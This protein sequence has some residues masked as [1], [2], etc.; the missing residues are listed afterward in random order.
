MVLLQELIHQLFIVTVYG[1]PRKPWSHPPPSPPPCSLF[2]TSSSSL[3][4]LF[5]Y[6]DGGHTTQDVKMGELAFELMSS[7]HR[8][9]CRNGRWEA[10]WP[11]FIHAPIF[12][13]GGVRIGRWLCDHLPVAARSPDGDRTAI[14]RFVDI[15]RRS[16]GA[17]TAI[18]RSPGDGRRIMPGKTGRWQLRSAD[19]RPDARRWPS[20]G[21]WASAQSCSRS[22][23]SAGDLPMS[24]NRH[25][26]TNGEKSGGH[27]TISKACDAALRA[28]DFLESRMSPY[29]YSLGF[30]NVLYWH[31]SSWVIK[32]IC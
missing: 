28:L 17:L 4:F 9:Y 30:L 32:W 5:R 2:F 1:S 31:R 12:G 3:F 24:K 14:D 8:D 22:G 26:A 21:R 20:G 27:R 15:A 16:P 23:E 13:G 25:P 19:H 11:T 7:Q 18:G 10:R 29:P 6:N